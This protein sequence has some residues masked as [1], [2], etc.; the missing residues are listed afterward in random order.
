MYVNLSCDGNFVIS[1]YYRT[2]TYAGRRT[3]AKCC[4]DKRSNDHGGTGVPSL[5]FVSLVIVSK[6]HRR[7]GSCFPHFLE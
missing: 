6:I 7:G 2:C 4:C 1:M 5:L 3:G